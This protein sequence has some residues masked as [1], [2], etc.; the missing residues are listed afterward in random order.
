MRFRAAAYA[1]SGQRA[2]R[3]IDPLDDWL[4]WFDL[5]LPPYRIIGQLYI[6]R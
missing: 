6:L 1:L 3:W 4:G 2:A 5:V